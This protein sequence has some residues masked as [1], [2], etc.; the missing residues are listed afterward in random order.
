MCRVSPT[1][2][3]SISTPR[4]NYL[5]DEEKMLKFHEMIPNVNFRD[6]DYFLEENFLVL[7]S[8]VE[9]SLSLL[10]TCFME[11]IIGTGRTWR[12]YAHATRWA[13]LLQEE[14]GSSEKKSRRTRMAVFYFTNSFILRT[15]W[16]P[17]PFPENENVTAIP[18]VTTRRS[19]NYGLSWADCLGWPRRLD[20]MLPAEWLCSSNACLASVHHLIGGNQIL[21]ELRKDPKAGILIRPIPIQHLRVGVVTDA[22]WGNVEQDRKFLEENTKDYWEETPVSWVRHHTTPRR[23]EQLPM[24]QIYIASDNLDEPSTTKRRKKMTGIPL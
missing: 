4:M 10:T 14:A 13:S 19:A 3:C 17:F 11:E 5:L 20:Q 22:A 18:S 1:L 2:A 15:R 7:A 8:F 23:L 24:G 16:N 12:F 9:L 21:D 6:K